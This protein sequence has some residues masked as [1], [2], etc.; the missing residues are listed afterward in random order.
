MTFAEDSAESTTEDSH[1]SNWTFSHEVEGDYTYVGRAEIGAA[2]LAEQSAS[3]QYV[4]TAQYKEGVPLRTG[5]NWQRF[6]FSSAGFTAVPNTLQ[7]ESFIAGLDYELPGSIFVR[8][9]AQPG[10]YNA[11]SRVSPRGFN[12]PVVVGGSWLYNKDLQFVLGLSIDATRQYPVLPGGG[13]RW[14]INSQWLLNAILPKPR[15]EL[16]ITKKLTAFAGADFEEASYR[17]D[18]GFGEAH[19]NE[20]LN[21][22]WLDFTEVR[23]GAGAIWD[24]SA[25]VKLELEAGS[26]VYRELN[27]H[28]ADVSVHSSDAA[29]Y[30]RVGFSAKF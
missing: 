26:L 11:S 5:F 18:P 22:Q 6:S 17:T 19:R 27:Y 13:I 30:G 3:A 12:I 15:L 9:E 24:I 29:P 28:R 7:S 4:L 16:A 14:Q 2:R 10:F 21:S 20:K 1:A 8:L 25:E 23:A